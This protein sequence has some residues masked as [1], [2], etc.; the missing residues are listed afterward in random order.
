MTQHPCPV[1]DHPG[2]V[3]YA[4]LG[5][6]TDVDCPSC[7]KIRLSGSA[8]PRLEFA[9]ANG[10]DVA[11]LSKKLREQPQPREDGRLFVMTYLLRELGVIE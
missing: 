9:K 3:R 6:R 7:G 5:P 4:R 11:A 1:C 8:E 10:L 2:A